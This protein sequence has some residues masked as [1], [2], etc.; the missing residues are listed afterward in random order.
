[1]NM[2]DIRMIIKKTVMTSLLI[3][4]FIWQGTSLYGMMLS[5]FAV[6]KST[7]LLSKK[8][9][10]SFTKRRYCDSPK[11]GTDTIEGLR[12]TI[13]SLK[14]DTDSLKEDTV[15]LEERLNSVF[16]VSGIALALSV[17]N[18]WSLTFHTTVDHK[19]LHPCK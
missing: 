8:L 2:E 15:F 6:Q 3:L 10:S 14:K 19:Y 9:L 7:K 13:D 1:M 17:I 4:S 11:K 5:R 16:C 12:K 18:V